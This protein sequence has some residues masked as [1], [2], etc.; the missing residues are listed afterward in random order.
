MRTLEVGEAYLR[1]V[2]PGAKC[3]DGCGP[4]LSLSSTD[5]RRPRLSSLV[6]ARGVLP[7]G[8]RLYEFGGRP[9]RHSKPHRFRSFAGS[10][11]IDFPGA[12]IGALIGPVSCVSYV[13][14]QY[15]VNAAETHETVH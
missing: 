7:I 6:A 4:L 5:R 1:D 2:P 3:S 8:R 10:A 15:S 9:G 14:W 13:S 12:P 11:P